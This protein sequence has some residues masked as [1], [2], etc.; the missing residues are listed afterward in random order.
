M[1]SNLDKEGKPLE[2]SDRR[3]ISISATGCG[4]RLIVR[5]IPAKYSILSARKASA[6]KAAIPSSPTC[7]RL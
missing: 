2:R 4:T 6:A 1:W 3:R 5:A 7:A